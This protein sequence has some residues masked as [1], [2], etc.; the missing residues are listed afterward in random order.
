MRMTFFNIVLIL[1]YKRATSAWR[2]HTSTKGLSYLF[3]ACNRP[4]WWVILI[5][6][7]IVNLIIFGILAFS[8]K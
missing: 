2:K 5:L 7:P 6:I 1:Y 3:Q 8:K 4:G